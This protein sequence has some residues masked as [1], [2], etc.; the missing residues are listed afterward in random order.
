MRNLDESILGRSECVPLFLLFYFT[1]L[2][3][4]TPMDTAWKDS[5][6]DDLRPRQYSELLH[7]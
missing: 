7:S 1:P 6:P 3:V 4:A 5:T 2:D